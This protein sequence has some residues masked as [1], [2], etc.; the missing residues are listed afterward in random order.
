MASTMD[1]IKAPYR[2]P[3]PSDTAI[4]ANEYGQVPRGYGARDMFQSESA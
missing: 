1:A 2:A 3:A 4:Q